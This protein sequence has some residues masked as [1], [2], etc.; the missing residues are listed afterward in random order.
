[1]K[2]WLRTARLLVGIGRDV[3]PFITIGTL[4]ANAIDFTAPILVAIGSRPFVDGITSGSRSSMVQGAALLG[5]SMV[6][7]VMMPTLYRWFT[8][9]ARE[10]SFMVL[11]RRLLTLS[12]RAPRL[13]HFE[14]PEFWD[15][16]QT[17]RK[18]AGELWLGLSL[19]ILGPILL[20]ELVIAAVLLGQIEPW[21]ALI[22]VVAVPAVWATR[23][24]ERL[25][26]AAQLRAAPYSRTSEHLFRL[27][28]SASAG[29][30][31]RLYGLSSDLL[32]RHAT[33]SSA[34]ARLTEAAEFRSLLLGFGGRVLFWSRTRRASCWCC[35]KRRPGRRRRATW[36]WC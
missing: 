15:R 30:E 28:S 32:G 20:A 18:S 12:T 10:R 4:L 36:R 24:A 8:I 27:A 9:R 17:L 21:L 34:A 26:R 23:F 31:T 2:E 19:G 33:A 13:A 29:M 14:R 6:L 22:P 7:M 11:Q 25:Q 35:A 16:L 5:G 3:G 1:V